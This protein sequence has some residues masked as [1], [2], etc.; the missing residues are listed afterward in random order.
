MSADAD[1]ANVEREI[2]AAISAAA[3]PGAAL[4]VGAGAEILHESYAGSLEPGGPQVTERTVYDLSSLTKPLATLGAAL[5]LIDAGRLRFEDRVADFAPEL[6]ADG[7]DGGRRAGITIEDLLRHRSGLPAWRPYWQQLRER[8]PQAVATSAGR[9]S[10][11]GYALAEPLE[12]APRTRE[13]YSDVGFI[14]LGELIE[15]VAGRALDEIFDQS[16]AAPLGLR[17]TAYRPVECA[18]SEV[19]HIAPCGSCSWRG[20][21]VRGVVQDENAYAMGGVA[22]HAGLFGTAREVH[23]VVGEHVAAAQDRTSLFDPAL[24]RRCWERSGAAARASTWTIGWD[25]PT[26]GESS[27]GR[28]VSPT[29]VG[30]LGFTGT[31]IWIDRERGVHVVLLTNRL[32]P[33]RENTAV[34]RVRP[35]VHDAVFTAVDARAGGAAARVD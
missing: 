18:T 34:R 2:S 11:A 28:I 9:S 21:V 8:R 23:R 3:F 14:I 27:A 6:L 32:H 25:T 19:A 5:L 33:D 29:A 15:R 16:I 35:S 13:L 30:H 31:S 4:L 1:W 22:G 12:Y 24:V 17:D 20:A 26:P 7:D 10:V